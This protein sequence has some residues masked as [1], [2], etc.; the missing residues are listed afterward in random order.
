M[1]DVDS[2][3]NLE[4]LDRLIKTLGKSKQVLQ[5]EAV[6]SE[7]KD[8]PANFGMNCERHCICSV[9]GQLPCPGL[10]P[11]PKVLRGK[12]AMGKADLDEE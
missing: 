4:I 11:L 5:E 3:N 8:N 7:K 6:A 9:Y 1:F 12:Y 10:I 2:Q